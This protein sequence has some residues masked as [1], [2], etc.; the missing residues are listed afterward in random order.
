MANNKTWL[1]T[2]HDEHGSVSW[3]VTDRIRWRKDKDTP[4]KGAKDCEIRLTDCYKTIN[5]DFSYSDREGYEERTV[6]LAKL[7]SELTACQAILNSSWTEPDLKEDEE[8]AVLTLKD[9]L[10]EE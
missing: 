8:E 9:L 5:L 2:K 1:N 6:K 10:E 3:S 4:V 7:I